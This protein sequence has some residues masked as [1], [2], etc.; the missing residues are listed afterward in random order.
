MFKNASHVMF[1][2]DKSWDLHIK[3]GKDLKNPLSGGSRQ[4][5]GGNL[6]SG[7]DSTKAE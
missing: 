2:E 6:L 5:L 3:K 7:R 4:G 1:Q